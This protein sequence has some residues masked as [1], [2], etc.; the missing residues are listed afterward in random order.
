MAQTTVSIRMDDELKKDM[1]NLCQ[2]LGMNLTTAFI[3]FAKQMVR[4]QGIPFEVTR[5]DVDSR[6]ERLMRYHDA[7][8]KREMN[9]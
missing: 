3:M 9:K 1:E 2:D 7:L 6:T 4:E 8:V 5:V